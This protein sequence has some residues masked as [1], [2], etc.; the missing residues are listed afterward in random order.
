MRFAEEMLI[1]LLNEET[2]YFLPIPEWKMS[3]ALAGSVLIDLALEH[4]IDSD[5]KTLTLLD[6]TPT[7]DELL[8]PVLKEVEQATDVHTPR[9]WVERIAR[10]SDEISTVALDRLVKW[11]ILTSDSGEFWSLSSKVARSRRYPVIER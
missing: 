11:G 2:G 8:D 9:F 3:C 6:P 5:L 10:R 1:L 4:R 7:G